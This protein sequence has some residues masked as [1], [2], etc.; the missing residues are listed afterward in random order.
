MREAVIAVLIIAPITLT[1]I[2]PEARSRIY[3]TNVS[4]NTKVWIGHLGTEWCILIDPGPPLDILWG[5][6]P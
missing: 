5:D 6:M 3:W 2:K 4:I 1:M